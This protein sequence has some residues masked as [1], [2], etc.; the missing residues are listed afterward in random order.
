ME[1]ET[2][3]TGRYDKP[4]VDLT[5]KDVIVIGGTLLA[6]KF[7]KDVALNMAAPHLRKWTKKMNERAAK[8][9][10]ETE[11]LDKTFPS[12]NK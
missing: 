6:V 11:R 8:M 3:E 2:I 4:I 10:A 5:A 12:K 1:T 9:K 7:C